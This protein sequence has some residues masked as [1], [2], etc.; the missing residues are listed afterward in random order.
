MLPSYCFPVVLGT[1]G[2]DRSL[3]DE[4]DN[5]FGNCPECLKNHSLADESDDDRLQ[6][7]VW[8]RPYVLPETAER[9]Q[10]LEKERQQRSADLRVR[11][12]RDV[13]E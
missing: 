2:Y 1:V 12:D 7:V 3:V 9:R 13:E 4:A 8:V 5:N 6:Y 10:E 11:I